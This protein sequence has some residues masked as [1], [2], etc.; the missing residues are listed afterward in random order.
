[1]RLQLALNVSDID[2]A[3]EFYGNLFGV[4]PHKRRPGYANFEVA[5]PP[6]KLV[7]FEQAELGDR[8]NH[9]GVEVEAA[10]QVGAA[11]DRLDAAGLTTDVESSTDCCFA[12]QD[13]VW[14]TD[15]D[16]ARWEVYAIL[17]DDPDGL[18]ADGSCAAPAGTTTI[19]VTGQA[20]CS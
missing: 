12:I 1:M 5:E 16:G 4:E 15:P 18:G 3:V 19:P 7:L 10:E 14:I 13:K 9:L 17:D 11:V 6:L 2:E 8:L 20:C